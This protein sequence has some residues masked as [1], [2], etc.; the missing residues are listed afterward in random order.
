MNEVVPDGNAECV[1][2]AKKWAD[3]IMDCSPMSIRATKQSAMQGTY[4]QGDLEVAFKAQRKLPAAVA[5]NKSK[6]FIEGP[7]A[8][9]EK[10]K[11]NWK[12]E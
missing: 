2:A 5:M 7:L 4:H 8:F 11:P 3:Q 12:G 9:S 1:A 6:D 10:R